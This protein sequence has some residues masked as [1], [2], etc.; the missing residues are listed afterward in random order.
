MRP[1]NRRGL[2]YPT[3]TAGEDRYGLSTRAATAVFWRS[4]RRSRSSG[5]IGASATRAIRARSSA[6]GAHRRQGPRD[7][8]R[9]R[10]SRRAVERR[11]RKGQSG[12]RS[13]YRRYGTAA[14]VDA[15]EAAAIRRVFAERTA[16]TRSNGIRALIAAAGIS[17]GPRLAASTARGTV[18]GRMPSPTLGATV[19]V[20]RA[21]I[22]SS[23]LERSSAA[24]CGTNAALLLRVR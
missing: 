5:G 22:A 12:P 19:S 7:P 23:D 15:S 17:R 9:W 10:R 13:A 6:A 21:P 3:R 2:Y 20:E 16:G 8:R 11:S 18:S 14:A 4:A 1:S 24:A